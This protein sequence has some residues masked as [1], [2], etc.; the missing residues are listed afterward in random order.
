MIDNISHAKN[1]INSENY[2]I[3][4]QFLDKELEQNSNKITNEICYY[5][6]IALTNIGMIKGDKTLI[7]SGIQYFEKLIT[8]KLD[9]DLIYFPDAKNKLEEANEELDKL[10]R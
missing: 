5:K 7:E 10:N 8:S 3:A 4:L 2:E 6:G 1:N 9:S